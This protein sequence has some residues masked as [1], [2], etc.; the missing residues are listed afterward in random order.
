LLSPGAMRRILTGLVVAG[1]LASQAA[2]VITSQP[3]HRGN[4]SAQKS[5]CHPS[6]YW[7]GKQC[8]HKGK[9]HGARKHDNRRK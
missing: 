4:S 3:R 5:K 7:D 9:G 1:F 6:Q 8:R 2:C